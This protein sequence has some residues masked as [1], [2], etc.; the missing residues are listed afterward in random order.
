M[1]IKITGILTNLQQQVS[2][3]DSDVRTQQV[4]YLSELCL[5][6]ANTSL[7]DYFHSSTFPLSDS[8]EDRDRIYFDRTEKKLYFRDSDGYKLTGTDQRKF[9]GEVAGFFSGGNTGS[10]TNTI[11][12]FSLATDGNATNH[13]SLTISVDDNAGHSSETHGYSSGGETSSI[14]AIIDKFSFTTPASSTNIGNLTSSRGN[15]AGI[16]ASTYQYG[17]SAGGNNVSNTNIIDRFSFTVDGSASDVGDLTTNKAS[18]AGSNSSTDGYVTGGDGSTT[19]IDKFS[20]TRPTA[21]AATTASLS[22]AAIG[23]AGLSSEQGY[24]YNVYVDLN[25]T[26][27][28]DKFSF[29]ADTNASDVGDLTLLVENNS[30]GVSSTE[31]GF[32]V[33][34]GDASRSDTIQKF[35]FYTDGTSIDVG[36]LA[37]SRNKGSAQQY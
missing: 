29:T 11:E 2:L 6:A 25:N 30:G 9:Q 18:S 1:T 17:Y 14:I 20:F 27:V 4:I 22:S 7:Q 3:V 36:N 31:R 19:S 32:I 21:N 37:N 15:L 13:G 26:N 33:G 24:G 28:I 5:D 23:G 34:G 12:T 10:R 8:E 16:S 35:S